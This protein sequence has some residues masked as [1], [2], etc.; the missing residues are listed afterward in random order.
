MEISDYLRV[1]WRRL[2]ILVLVPLLAG[3]IV[4]SMVLRE[5]PKYSA[6]ADVAAPA[7][8]GGGSGQYSGPNGIKA[9]VANFTA[10]VVSPQ[11]VNA[12]SK[13]TKV[14]VDEINS[15]LSSTPV[16]DSGLIDVTFTTT[17]KDNAGPVAKTAASATMTALFAG[18]VTLAKSGLTAANNAYIAAQ[19]KLTDFRTA[20]QLVTDP[21]TQFSQDQSQLGNAQNGRAG[22]LAAAHSTAGFDQ[23]IA[24]L[25][26][27]INKLS[28]LLAPYTTLNDNVT[29]AKATFDAANNALAQAAQISQA[30]SPAT[31]VSVNATK[32]ASFLPELVKKAA[33]AVGAGLF[34]AVLIVMMVE[35]VAR[36]PRPPG[37]P[38]Y[39]SSNSHS[40]VT[41]SSTVYRG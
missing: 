39:A 35:L 22:A 12:V 10:L 33:P 6:T 23:Q 27:D 9:F 32:A 19:K 20:H 13:S 11:V 5:P 15:G 14:T 29:T 40:R 21:N 28:P 25:Q 1:I 34:L 30:A 37:D 36:R 17:H 8:V 4:T 16:G 31:T 7:V 24:A 38:R 3:G 41:S 26:A 2:W 18:Q